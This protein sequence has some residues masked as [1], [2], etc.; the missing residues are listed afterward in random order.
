MLND[1][2][3]TNPIVRTSTV[4]WRNKVK[5][6]AYDHLTDWTSNRHSILAFTYLDMSKE[7]VAADTVTFVPPN[8]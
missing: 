5:A 2:H 7:R 8:G 4:R 6:L 1:I 3:S